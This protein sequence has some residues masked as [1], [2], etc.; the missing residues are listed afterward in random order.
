MLL[1]AQV[2]LMGFDLKHIAKTIEHFFYAFLE[3]LPLFLEKKNN[4]KKS[5]WKLSILTDLHIA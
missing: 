5:E 4:Q 3:F 1:A 2:S